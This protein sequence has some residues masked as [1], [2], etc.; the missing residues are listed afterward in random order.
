MD[1]IHGGQSIWIG[2]CQIL[3]AVFPGLRVPCPPSPPDSWLE[4]R[5]PPR[6][7]FPSSSPF[8][9]GYGN[10]V[11]ALQIN[12]RESAE[13]HRRRPDHFAPMVIIGIGFIVSF[14]VAYAAVAWFMNWVRKRGFAPFAIY[15][16]IVGA[17]VLAW[18]WECSASSD[19]PQRL[20]E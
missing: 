13:S 10:S 6:W 18:R 14:I 17:A 15:R 7:S 20:S 8:H 5:A 19:L 9:H 4:S 12:F 11:H 16:I 2:A 3:S 1:D